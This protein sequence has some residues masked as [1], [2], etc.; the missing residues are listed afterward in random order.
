MLTFKNLTL[1]YDK[2]PAVHHLNANV[3]KGDTL[4]IVGPNGGGKST[5]IKSIVGLS[6]I[7]DGKVEL[8]INKDKIAYLPQ[9][10]TIDKTFPIS[11]FELISTG[12]WHKTGWFGN[13]KKEYINKIH[14]VI[15]QVGLHGMENIPISALSG[16]QMQRALF[17][18]LILQN[19]D[20][21]LLD[22]PFNA[23]DYKT[24]QV[25]LNIIDSWKKENKTI[26]SILHNYN[27]VFDHFDKTL[28]IAKEVVAFG[29]TSEVLTSENINIA[30]SI[31]TSPNENA[32]IC[33][34]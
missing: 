2:H 1:G 27:Q 29:K 24:I 31:S 18:R 14:D 33:T 6:K 4:A 12:L 9:N 13:F 16:G 15:C 7:L 19:A 30:F 17:A 8:S 34:R 3:E 20:L 32:A 23:V 22:E 10:S 5:L 11:T 25:L 21:I 28:I 26:I